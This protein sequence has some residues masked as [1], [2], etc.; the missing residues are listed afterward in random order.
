MACRGSGPH[1]VG[2]RQGERL[3]WPDER[4]IRGAY[5]ELATSDVEAYRTVGSTDWPTP[6]FA[7]AATTAKMPPGFVSA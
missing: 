1:G 5:E 4:N 3:R 6:P 7:S 2:R